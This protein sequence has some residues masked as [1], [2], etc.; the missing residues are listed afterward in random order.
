M[1]ARNTPRR[2]CTL[3][4]YDF[5]VHQFH[6][7]GPDIIHLAAPC[8]LVG[9][10]QR[11][12]DTLSLGHLPDDSV[13]PLLRLL[14]NIGKVAVQP[15]AEQQAGIA[16]LAVFSDVPQVSLTPYDMPTGCSISEGADRQWK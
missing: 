16:G 7:A 14:T 4:V 3:C 8:H 5:R 6:R 1:T 15:A 12:G 2:H 13:Q 11:L 10:F 9:S